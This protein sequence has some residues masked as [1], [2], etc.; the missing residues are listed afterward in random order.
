MNSLRRLGTPVFVIATRTD[1]RNAGGQF[2]RR[3]YGERIDRVL[4]DLGEGTGG[5]TLRTGR[6]DERSWAESFETIRRRLAEQL[7]VSYDSPGG[8]PEAVRY[9]GKRKSVRVVLLRPERR[10]ATP[11]AAGD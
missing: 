10:C 2:R 6:P 8:W 5:G 11:P 3:G 7:L 4:T 1:S 9:T